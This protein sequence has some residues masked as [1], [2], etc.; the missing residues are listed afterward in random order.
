MTEKKKIIAEQESVFNNGK[1][2]L[3]KRGK[4]IEQFAKNNIISKDEKFYDAP[5]K[6]E[7]IISEKSEQ[8]FDQSIPKWVQVLEDRF[9]FIK[10]K[11]NINKNLVTMIN[12]Q[13]YILNDINELVNKITKKKMAKIK[14]LKNTA[15]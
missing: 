14:P 10:L 11:I 15:V 7:E 6:S 1:V 4:L 13:R 8:K 5:K 3:E 2:L 12:N 9:N